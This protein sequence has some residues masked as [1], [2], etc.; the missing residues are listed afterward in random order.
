MN[1]N[2]LRKFPLVFLNIW[3]QYEEWTQILR[4]SFLCQTLRTFIIDS[5][6]KQTEQL[7]PI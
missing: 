5:S 6:P 7:P 3:L 2:I 1:L 4:T